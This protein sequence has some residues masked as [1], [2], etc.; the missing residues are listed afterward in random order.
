MNYVLSLDLNVNLTIVFY[1]VEVF[2][3]VLSQETIEIFEYGQQ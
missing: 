2:Y 1:K 3:A